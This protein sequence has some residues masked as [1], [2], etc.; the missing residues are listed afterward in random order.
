MRIELIITIITIITFL[1]QSPALTFAT[2]H[3]MP[4]II[5]REFLSNAKFSLPTLQTIW[6]RGTLCGVVRASFHAPRNCEMAYL[7]QCF[8]VDMTQ[9]PS[10]SVSI[11][12]LKAGNALVAPVVLHG[13]VCGGNHL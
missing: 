10:K 13:V 11:S 6:I 8:Q 2:Q 3:A 4:R 9:A 5:R 12:T 7:R 1:E